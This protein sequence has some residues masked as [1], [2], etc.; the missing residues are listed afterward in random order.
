M[1]SI[2]SLCFLIYSIGSSSNNYWSLDDISIIGVAVSYRMLS[3]KGSI[4]VIVRGIF[5]ADVTSLITK[6]IVLDPTK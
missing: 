5:V 2:R 4:F 6:F 3:M 1:V